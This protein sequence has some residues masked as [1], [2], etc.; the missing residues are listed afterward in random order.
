LNNAFGGALGIW[1]LTKRNETFANPLGRVRRT[2]DSDEGDFTGITESPER[3]NAAAT[4][5]NSAPASHDGDT[6]ATFIGADDGYVPNVYDQV[7]SVDFAQ[8]TTGAQAKIA[9]AG[10]I[11]TTN[12]FPM[13]TFASSDSEI[14]WN[15]TTAPAAY[16]GLSDAITYI[17]VI[18]PATMSGTGSGYSPGYTIIEMRVNA[19]TSASKSPFSFGISATRL[20]VGFTNNYIVGGEF[21]LSPFI[22]TTGVRYVVAFTVNGD[23]V[24]I[25]VDGVLTITDTLTIATGDR[26]VTTVNS[27]F[28]RGVRTRDGGQPD[29]AYF[30]GDIG[31][32]AI[33]DTVLTD[34]EIAQL[35]TK[36]LT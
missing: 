22:L 31:T 2:S 29:N 34:T 15:N 36:Y 12:G 5:S 35:T 1:S 20:Q 25:Y 19:A 32:D 16:Q 4:A 6:F 3:L 23:V 9:T 8:T 28:T 13:R 33:Y 7:G 17:A 18:E 11:N 10:T 26:S 21:V 30:S 27:S 14:G 24:K